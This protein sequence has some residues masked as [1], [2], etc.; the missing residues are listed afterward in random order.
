MGKV[1][2]SDPAASKSSSFE[3]EVGKIAHLKLKMV[4]VIS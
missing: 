4:C 1:T 2:L 3:I